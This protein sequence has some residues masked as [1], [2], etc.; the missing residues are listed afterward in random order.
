MKIRKLSIRNIGPFIEAE[1]CFFSDADKKQ[2]PVVL[3]TGENGTGKSIILDAIR[4]M[5]GPGYGKL[6]RD[7]R[8]R[9]CE[10][11]SYIKMI[12]EPDG[13]ELCLNSYEIRKNDILPGSRSGDHHR[14]MNLPENVRKGGEC[15]NWIADF[16]P[17]ASGGGSYR[18][19]TLESP[20]HRKFLSGALQGLRT[21]ADITRLICHSDYVR[22]SRDPEERKVG[23]SL[24]Q[25]LERIIE[26]SLLDGGRLSHVSRST[27]E[28]IIIQNSQ[29]VSLENLSSG[30]LYLIQNMA[31]LLSK[32]YSVLMLRQA[33][34]SELC[35]TPGLLLIDE[36]ENP[37]QMAEAVHPLCPGNF[38]QPPDHCQDAFPIYHFLCLKCQAFRMQRRDRPLC[39]YG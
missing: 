12:L 20:D 18:I 22:D 7:I 27:Y 29:A 25:I 11:K 13:K 39:G 14:L 2:S 5:F 1:M 10:G 24:Y 9:K 16:W 4:G 6:E 3:I 37:S 17:S 36:A 19:D 23:E 31:G 35:L 34:L 21:N 38:S 8:R 28:P 15:P 30:N 32:M 26:K 33:R